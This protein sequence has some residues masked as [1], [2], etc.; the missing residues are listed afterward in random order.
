[1][2]SKDSRKELSASLVSVNCDT[3]VRG[4]S[5]YPWCHNLL[6]RRTL[7]ALREEYISYSLLPNGQILEEDI[8]TAS[9]TAT[10]ASILLCS[11]EILMGA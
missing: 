3:L 9:T 7:R 5:A 10:T 8:A 2:A 1:M 4:L 6:L 11:L